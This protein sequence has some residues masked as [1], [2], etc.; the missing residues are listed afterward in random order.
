MTVL[1]KHTNINK[2]HLILR[3]KTVIISVFLLYIITIKVK[4]DRN[5]KVKTD[6]N[7]KVKVYNF[8]VFVI[9]IYI[10]L[11]NNFIRFLSILFNI[12]L[13]VKIKSKEVFLS[14]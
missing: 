10:Y 3:V 12:N 8:I 7:V 14:M 11:Q 9:Y 13:Y 1:L 2:V 6:K 5:V 4:T